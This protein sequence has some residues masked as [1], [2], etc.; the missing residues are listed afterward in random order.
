MPSQPILRET[1]YVEAPYEI[2]PE[3]LP[4][5]ESFIL[6]SL[7]KIAQQRATKVRDPEGQFL[8]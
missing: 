6:N 1:E 4:N 3:E 5:L 7:E 8:V 2:I